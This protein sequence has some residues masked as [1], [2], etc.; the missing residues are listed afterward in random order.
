[1]TLRITDV[2]GRVI[3][4]IAVPA[5]QQKVTGSFDI[6]AEA[7]GLYHLE[8]TQGDNRRIVKLGVH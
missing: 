2:T 7:V 1:M 6:T 5:G 3:Q 4:E 8:V